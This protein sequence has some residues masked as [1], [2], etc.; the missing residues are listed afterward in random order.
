[1]SLEGT[2]I[3]K[4]TSMTPKG[5]P[6]PN[7]TFT[8]VKEN[9][10]SKSISKS[11]KRNQIQIWPSRSQ[12]GNQ[13]PSSIFPFLK[14]HPDKSSNF[15]ISPY[16]IY[17][18]SNFS[19]SELHIIFPFDEKFSLYRSILQNPF[20][21]ERPCNVKNLSRLSLQIK[22][23]NPYNSLSLYKYVEPIIGGSFDS[24]Q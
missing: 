20:W 8:S 1:M 10:N 21:C 15:L 23:H 9:S 24:A 2:Q 14:R 18:L 6:S 12:M 13:H 11:L 22:D 7:S 5:K 16:K 19:T 3:S 4:L 17:F